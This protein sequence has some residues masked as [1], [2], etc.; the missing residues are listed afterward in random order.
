MIGNWLHELYF[1]HENKHGNLIGENKKM[2]IEDL[3]QTKHSDRIADAWPKRSAE[4]LC[5]ES[6]DLTALL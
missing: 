5:Q 1:M 3:A 6:E 2:K 4:K